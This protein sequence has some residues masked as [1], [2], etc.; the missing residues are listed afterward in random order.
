MSSDLNKLALQKEYLDKYENMV[1][2]LQ[3]DQYTEDQKLDAR[4]CFQEVRERYQEQTAAESNGEEQGW[5]KI[6]R[7]GV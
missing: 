4:A 3:S 5:Q 2:V 6:K 7:R 1:A